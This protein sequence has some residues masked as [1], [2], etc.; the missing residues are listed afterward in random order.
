MIRKILIIDDSAVARKMLKKSMPKGREYEFE[1]AVDGEDGVDKFREFKPDVVFMDLTMP[2]VDGFK[3]TERIMG[4][5]KSTIIIVMTA[6][7][8]PKSV[9]TITELGAFTVLK[10]PARTKLIEEALAAAELKIKK[11]SGAT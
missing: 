8:Q 11:I 2:V 4:L 10:K 7:I 9:A 3:S 6:D 1:E 5:N